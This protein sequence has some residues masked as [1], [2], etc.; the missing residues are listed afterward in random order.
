MD[1]NLS[2][3]GPVPEI[4]ALFWDIGG[5]LLTNAWDHEE[6]NLA[7]ERFGLDRDE[8]ETRHKASVQPFEEGRTTLDEYLKHT[9]FYQTRTFSPGEFKDF[10]YG[11]SKPKP[12][13]LDIARGLRGKYL[14]GTINNE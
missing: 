6:R 3:G 5:V 13:V 12:D 14:I 9:V 11:L 2:L 4:R 7:I 10:M 1:Q 8:F